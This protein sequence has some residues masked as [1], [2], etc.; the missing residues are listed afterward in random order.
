MR[1]IFLFALLLGA[2]HAQQNLVPNGDFTGPDPL[3]SWRIDFPYQ[4][5]Y[6]KNAGYM[7]VVSQAGRKCIELN[8]PPG[9]AGNEGGKVETAF[10]PAVPGA[11]YRASIDCLTWDFG[12]KLHAEAYTTDPRPDGKQNTSLFVIPGTNGAPG[13]V[14]CYRAQFPDPPGHGRQWST[15]TREFTLPASI[16]VAGKDCPPE[17]IVLK[18][19]AYAG[20]MEAGKSYF[21]NFRLDKIK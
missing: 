9:V 2:A 7:K 17:F 4:S 12:A 19:V 15:I 6:V 10:I 16:K 1:T 20:T 3:K 21:T 5:R 8:L 18:V 13:K 11:T 14:M